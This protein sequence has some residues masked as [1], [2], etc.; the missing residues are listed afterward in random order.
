[1]D[2][3]SAQEDVRNAYVRGS[4]AQ[5]IM[6]V[7]WLVAAG[8]GNWVSEYAAILVMVLAVALTFP[9]TLLALHLLGRPMGLPGG[10]PMTPLVFQ[11]AVV[12]P[13]SLILIGPISLYN[14]NWFFPALMFVM[15]IH[16]I[17]FIFLYGMWEFGVLV[18]ALLTGGIAIGLLYPHA[19]APAGW[20][21]GIVLLVFAL[22]VQLTA[23]LSKA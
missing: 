16:Y 8:L 12:I 3:R 7:F 14:L 18:V 20:F 21:T 6:G 17:P 10:H 23:R 15:G 11:V 13:L 4:L 1:M 2:I 9:V 5:G 19:F 22:L